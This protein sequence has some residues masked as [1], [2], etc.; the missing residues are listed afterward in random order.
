VPVPDKNS[1]LITEISN[2]AKEYSKQISHQ[3]DVKVEVRT[4]DKKGNFFG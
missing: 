4:M 1:E 2:N 3:R